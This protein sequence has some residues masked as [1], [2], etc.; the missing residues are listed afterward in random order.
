MTHPE[1][2]TRLH[3]VISRELQIYHEI[4]QLFKVSAMDLKPQTVFVEKE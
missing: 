3:G 1:S 4:V 2:F